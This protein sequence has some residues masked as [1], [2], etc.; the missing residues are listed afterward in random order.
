ML[1]D[2]TGDTNQIVARSDQLAKPTEAIAW[3]SQQTGV[4]GGHGRSSIPGASIEEAY[5]LIRELCRMAAPPRPGRTITVVIGDDEVDTYEQ[6][7]ASGQLGEP[8][9]GTELSQYRDRD[10]LLNTVAGWYQLTGEWTTG[11]NGQTYQ[12]VPN[13]AA[14]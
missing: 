14:R 7:L 4:T 3:A 11:D 5:D 13:T 12:H 8:L 1:D 2:A 9:Y 10:D 6:Y